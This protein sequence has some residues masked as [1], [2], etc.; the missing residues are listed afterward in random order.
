MY[1][2]FFKDLI[3]L[4]YSILSFKSQFKIFFLYNNCDKFAIKLFVFFFVTII[5]IF[6][7]FTYL[8]VN[9]FFL[10]C[11]YKYDFVDIIQAIK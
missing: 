5:K 9:L 7:L 3:L 11:K 2:I 6:Y 10:F 4:V 1:Y 8:F